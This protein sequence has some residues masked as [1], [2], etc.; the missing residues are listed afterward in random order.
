M[1]TDY[2]ALMMQLKN[3]EIDTFTVEPADF[4][5]F[6]TAYMAFEFRKRIIGK[7]EKNGTVIYHYDHDQ[8]Q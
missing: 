3:G 8:T 4:M 7:A 1:A 2:T 6:Q 5:T